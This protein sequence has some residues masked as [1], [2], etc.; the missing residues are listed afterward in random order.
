MRHP[1]AAA[2]LLVSLAAAARAQTPGPGDAFPSKPK[3]SVAEELERLCLPLGLDLDPKNPGAAHPAPEDVEAFNRAGLLSW[4]NTQL[5]TADDSIAASPEGLRV[6][7]ESR[8]DNILK[9]AALLQKRAPEW[10]RG[11]DPTVGPQ[12]ELAAL[13]GLQRVLLC[14]ALVEEREEKPIEGDGLLE[15]SWSLQRT[16]TGR[17]DLVFRIIAMAVSTLQA[18]ALRK[19]REPPVPWLNRLLEDDPWRGVLD[20]FANGPGRDR[21][22][23]KNSFPAS[24]DDVFVRSYR[25]VADGLRRVGPCEVSRLSPEEIWR[26]A[27]EVF[28][29]DLGP[30]G[31]RHAEVF[32]S[33]SFPNLTLMFRRAGRV[34]VDREL[35]RKILELRLRKR[36]SSE[37][38]WPKKL[39]DEGSA[40][41][42]G[43]SYRYQALRE[44][45]E[46]R[47]D[48]AI[49]SP[50]SGFFL[51][52]G[53]ATGARRPTR[54]PV[55]TPRRA[56]APTA[57]PS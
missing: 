12:P 32:R 46:V 34:L 30:G 16:L 3:D 38:R 14:A 9:V 35:T 29:T 10:G 57:E 6:Y 28:E 1:G 25:A 54:T 44:D 20:A 17:D 33:A 26:P 40:V 18:G 56:A 53:F 43:A 2:V 4:L 21:P 27:V 31:R 50:S 5:Q 42:P 22:A 41:C 37:G 51:P 8:R 47:F 24:F 13:I 52:L 49:D 45:M 48:G 11:R 23:G 7:L 15:A 55:Q 19:L 39:L 36:A